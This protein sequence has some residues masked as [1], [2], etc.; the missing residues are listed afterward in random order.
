MASYA[1]VAAS[2]PSQTAE[3]ARAPPVDSVIPTEPVNPLVDVDSGVSVVPPDFLSQDVQTETQANRIEIE[4]ES[5]A[6]QREAAE[7][8][9]KEGGRKGHGGDKK[10]SSDGRR[11]SVG[12]RALEV[13]PDVGVFVGWAVLGVMA[14]LGYGGYTRYS[15]GRLGWATAG[16]W[17]AGGVAGVIGINVAANAFSDY[18]R[19]NRQK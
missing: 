9:A 8:R 4:A 11:K 2:G 1:A 16:K 17:V 3:E 7:M 18:R 14:F 6:I 13:E 12:Q 5:R 19:A 10:G 15:Q